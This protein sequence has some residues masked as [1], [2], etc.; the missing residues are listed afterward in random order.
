MLPTAFHYYLSVD[1]AFM[2]LLSVHAYFQSE[3]VLSVINIL[4][5]VIVD[6]NSTAYNA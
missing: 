2:V 4:F 6:L 5:G 1:C 3:K